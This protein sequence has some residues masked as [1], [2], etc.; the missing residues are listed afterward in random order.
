[1]ID[2]VI[3]TSVS[4]ASTSRALCLVPPQSYPK[5]CHKSRPA[6]PTACVC[7]AYTY[8]LIGTIAPT[9]HRTIPL[10]KPHT[11][12]RLWPRVLAYATNTP[13]PTP[14]R[15]VN[16][17]TEQRHRLLPGRQCKHASHC[18]GRTATRTHRRC[19]SLSSLHHQPPP[20]PCWQRRRLRLFC[21]RLRKGRQRSVERRRRSASLTSVRRALSCGPRRPL[22]RWPLR[23]GRPAL[24][25]PPLHRPAVRQPRRSSGSGRRGVT[26]HLLG[27][28]QCA[29]AWVGAL[30]HWSMECGGAGK[31]QNT[32]LGRALWARTRAPS[33]RPF[34]PRSGAPPDRAAAAQGRF[35]H[36]PSVR[37]WPGA[38]PQRGGRWVARSTAAAWR[39]HHVAIGGSCTAREQRWNGLIRP[40]RP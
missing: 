18:A 5:T 26:R 4:W 17:D 31:W 19:L 28:P 29:R 36:T 11:A 34:H 8:I 2:F 7:G 20:P 37:R 22:G 6:E 30:V 9:A 23:C 32:S 24:H 35:C 39:N 3:A 25:R 15:H 16:N 1:M 13:R 33:P 40:P 10:T 21:Q 38:S 27:L 12:T 14:T